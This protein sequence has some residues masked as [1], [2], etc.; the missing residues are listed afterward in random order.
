MKKFIMFLACAAVMS[1]SAFAQSDD[2]FNQG[3]AMFD[4]F[5]DLYKKAIIDQEAGAATLM[6]R[7]TALMQG[8]DLLQQAL[9]ADTVPEIDKKTGQPKVDKN[10]N[11]KVKTKNSAKIV[12]MLS[13]H[14]NDIGGI[15]DNSW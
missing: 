13:E 12:T 15:G 10:G 14:F 11:V 1:V 9:K 5:D 3:K 2:L 8:F 6:E 7:S 4:K